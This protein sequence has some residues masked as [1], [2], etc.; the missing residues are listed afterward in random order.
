MPLCGIRMRKVLSTTDY[1][2]SLKFQKEPMVGRGGSILSVSTWEVIQKLGNFSFALSDAF[3]AGNVTHSGYFLKK[4][5]SLPLL[6]W[7]GK[8]ELSFAP[9]DMEWNYSV[10]LCRLC[11]PGDILLRGFAFNP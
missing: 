10:P 2:S 8:V 5:L 3:S 7:G 1:S 9:S 4:I 11:A 6:R